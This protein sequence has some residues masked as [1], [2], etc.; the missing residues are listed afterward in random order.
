MFDLLKSN[1]KEYPKVTIVKKAMADKNNKKTKFFIDKH[2]Y[3]G[4]SL[5]KEYS[6]INDLDKNNYEIIETISSDFFMKK[7]NML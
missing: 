2:N 3:D 5:F 4:S 1:L 7:N 6:K